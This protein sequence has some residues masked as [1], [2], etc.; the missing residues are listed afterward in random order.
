M[1]LGPREPSLGDAAR[2]PLARDSDADARDGEGTAEPNEERLERERRVE[3]E[4]GEVAPGLAGELG[5]LLGAREPLE[6]GV[7]S[8]LVGMVAVHRRFGPPPPARSRSPCQS[9]GRAPA[10]RSPRG[11]SAPTAA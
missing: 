5:R 3:V 7:R 1:A 4:L 10:P 2:Q 6:R 11:L 9:G 8:E